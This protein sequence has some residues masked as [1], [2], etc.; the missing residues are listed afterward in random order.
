MESQK[1]LM[2]RIMNLKIDLIVDSW[3]SRLD[4]GARAVTSPGQMRLLQGCWTS[5]NSSRQVSKQFFGGFREKMN[6]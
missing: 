4:A 2:P 6:F 5:L 3:R 1:T